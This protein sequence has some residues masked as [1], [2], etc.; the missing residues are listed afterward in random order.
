VWLSLGDSYAFGIAGTGGTS[1][2]SSA[3]AEFWPLL[4]FGA[5][6]R[7][8]EADCG[9]RGCREPVDVRTVLKL[10]FDPIERPELYD[11]LFGSGVVR[12]EEGVTDVF[13]GIIDGDLDSA[14]VSRV[15]GGGGGT[16][17]I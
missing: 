17:M 16:F 7:D 1:S 6:R 14:R 8:M 11:F 12:A 15:T 3:D 4:S 5:G 2:S 9:K 10:A 13:L